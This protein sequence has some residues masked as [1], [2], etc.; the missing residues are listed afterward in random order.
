MSAGDA[1][2]PVFSR[3]SDV[4]D[5]DERWVL[6]DMTAPRGRMSF[7][8]HRRERRQVVAEATVPMQRASSP[9]ERVEEHSPCLSTCRLPAIVF[10]EVAF[11][12]RSDQLI[13]S[14]RAE[15]KVAK[16]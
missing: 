3:R 6:V 5:L 13:S 11:R 1:S 15:V 4:R 10:R 16:R 9:K 12:R 2:W 14:G 7:I 8:R